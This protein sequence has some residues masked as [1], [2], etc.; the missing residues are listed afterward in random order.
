MN[1]HLDNHIALITGGAGGIGRAAAETFIAEGA[2]VALWDLDLKAATR[3][4]KEIST[5]TT[6]ALAFE[7]DI[8][9]ESSVQRALAQ[10]IDQFGPID[11]LVHAAAI[12]SGKF[13]FP[14]TN[15]TP[16]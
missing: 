5:P 8:A 6:R 15:L 2:H 16:S 4:A 13:G 14:F 1:F 10:T 7:C 11:H 12:G 9:D 3:I